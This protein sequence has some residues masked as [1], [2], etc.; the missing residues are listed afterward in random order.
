MNNNKMKHSNRIHDMIFNILSVRHGRKPSKIV[1]V[2]SYK[3]LAVVA[4]ARSVEVIYYYHHLF[5]QKYKII[6]KQQ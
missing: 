3:V 1:Y 4:H 2:Q 5:I 6:I